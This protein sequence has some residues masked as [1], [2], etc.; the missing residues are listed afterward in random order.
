MLYVDYGT[1]GEVEKKEV[2]FLH[3]RFSQD[4]VYAHRGCLDR[5]KP[6][7]GIWSLEAME[8]FTQHLSEFFAIPIMAKVTNINSEVRT[9]QFFRSNQKDY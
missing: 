6:N 2:R 8:K 7:D 5:C 9:L 1:V 4:P 3:K